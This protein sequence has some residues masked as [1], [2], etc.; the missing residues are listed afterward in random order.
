[1][2]AW[3]A[4]LEVFIGITVVLGG[5]AAFLTGRAIALSWRP[6]VVLIAYMAIL[7]GAARFIHFALFDGVLLSPSYYLV[8]F[9]VVLAFAGL[10]Y[11]MTR[12]HQM[13]TQ[14]RW[15]YHRFGPFGWRQLKN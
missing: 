6:A 7:A 5:T 15:L 4:N 8:D 3:M 1:M 11:R 13:A 2:D 9:L 12:A 10:G 14:Y